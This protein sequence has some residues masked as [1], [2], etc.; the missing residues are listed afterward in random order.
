M[1]DSVCIM[2]AGFLAIS[3]VKE[4]R[5]LAGAV[6]FEFSMHSVL[7]QFG[8][9]ETSFLNPSL[10]YLAY[11]VIQIFVMAYLYFKRSHFIITGLIFINLCL[12][13]LSFQE[14]ESYKF[15]SI[16]YIYPSLVGIIMIFELFY[17]GLINQCVSNYRTKNGKPDL[18]YIDSVFR[19]R[20]RNISGGLV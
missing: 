19:V 3:S 2:I 11:A 16:Y 5:F 13:L 10:I 18:D 17:L 12:N 15:M 9:V 4:Y 14:F 20:T 6:F 1:F 7:Y 8:I